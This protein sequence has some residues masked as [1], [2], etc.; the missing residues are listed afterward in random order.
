MVGAL[1]IRQGEADSKGLEIRSGRTHLPV[2]WVCRGK[3]AYFAQG[4]AT[5]VPILLVGG[6][7][8]DGEPFPRRGVW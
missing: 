5:K 6:A 7:P 2:P 4:V 1:A 8:G 3:F